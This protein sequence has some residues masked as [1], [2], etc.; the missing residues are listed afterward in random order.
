MSVFVYRKEKELLLVGVLAVFGEGLGGKKYWVMM[1]LSGFD[2]ILFTPAALLFLLSH[3]TRLARLLP[4]IKYAY[5]S[6]YLSL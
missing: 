2:Q 1:D 6:F 4:L 3:Y 5:F